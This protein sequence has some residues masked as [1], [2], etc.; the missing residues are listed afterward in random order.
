M[1]DDTVRKFSFPVPVSSYDAERPLRE[2][3]ID[4]YYT[5]LREAKQKTF[6]DFNTHLFWVAHGTVP[7]VGLPCTNAPQVIIWAHANADDVWRNEKWL[8]WLRQTFEC[9]VVGI[10][11]PG[12]AC[13]PGKPSQSSTLQSVRHLYRYLRDE[14]GF[15]PK[16]IILF[17]RS[18]GTG[19]LTE[20]A[21]ENQ[22]GALMLLSPF[23]SIKGVVRHGGGYKKSGSVAATLINDMFDSLSVIGSVQAPVLFIH[24]LE[25]SIVPSEHSK[26]LFAACKSKVKEII[27]IPTMGH[28][29]VFE[30][31]FRCSVEAAVVNFLNRNGIIGHTTR[32][33][34]FRGTGPKRS[35]GKF[36]SVEPASDSPIDQ[37]TFDETEARL[38]MLGAC[39]GSITDERARISEEDAAD[40]ELVFAQALRL[41]TKLQILF[42]QCN[43]TQDKKLKKAELL[44]LLRAVNR[45]CERLGQFQ[46][47]EQVSEASNTVAVAE[48]FAQ[49]DSNPAPEHRGQTSITFCDF[50]VMCVSSPTFALPMHPSVAV[51]VLLM[52]SKGGADGLEIDYGMEFDLICISEAVEA[53]GDSQQHS[54]RIT[55]AVASA[56]KQACLGRL[57]QMRVGMPPQTAMEAAAAE[58]AVEQDDDATPPFEAFDSDHMASA[59][60]GSWRWW[61][62]NTEQQHEFSYGLIVTDVEVSDN[63]KIRF[64][65]RS[66]TEGKYIVK[67]GEGE[68]DFQN[69][70]MKIKYTEAWSDMNEIMCATLF[71]NGRMVCDTADG[72]CQ[73]ARKLDTLPRDPTL[74]IGNK[75]WIQDQDSAQDTALA[76]DLDRMEAAAFPSHT[77]R[78]NAPELGARQWSCG[79]CTFLNELNDQSCVM[80]GVA[81]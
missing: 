1:F 30:D 29:D 52:L 22:V 69:G 10:E 49:Y 80:C 68:Y 31:P 56:E 27:L 66:M 46:D 17:G 35:L 5:V 55:E 61:A 57:R 43:V 63:G 37:W 24:G 18:I 9:H 39:L 47:L 38:A 64:K 14:Q 7:C 41:L 81:K 53:F 12:Y 59:L 36:D 11:Y 50:A 34:W 72:F 15:A 62:K 32:G 74:R 20:F 75:Y 65:G 26:R 40:P 25:D 79:T 45:E 70:A 6:E 76:Q 2:Y 42:Q 19:I 58:M 16:D 4:G 23:T 77:S 44:F 33:G 60:R 13:A 71:S 21:A 48:A 73:M 67:D 54:S 51:Q 3:T 8:Q 78:D 28:N